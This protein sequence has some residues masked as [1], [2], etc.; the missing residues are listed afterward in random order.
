MAYMY[1]KHKDYFVVIYMYGKSV[2]STKYK[3]TYNTKISPVKMP[4]WFY[5]IEIKIY[6]FN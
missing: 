4:I 6:L 3:T 5:R 2:A 1:C